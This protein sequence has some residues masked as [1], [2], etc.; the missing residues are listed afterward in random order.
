M[1]KSKNHTTHNQSR[2]WHRNGIKKPVSQRYES[3]KGV[4]PKFLRNMRFAKKHNKKGIKK[5]LANNAKFAAS[6]Q[7]PAPAK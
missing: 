1:A 3:L 5:M 6:A 7:A 2:K 4:D